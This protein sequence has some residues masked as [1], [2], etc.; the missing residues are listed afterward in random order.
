MAKKRAKRAATA[1]PAKKKAT[2]KKA[3]ARKKAPARRHSM[4]PDFAAVFMRLRGILRQFE[5]KM[6]VKQD[7]P[8][9][10]YMNT[11]IQTPRGPLFFGA[12]MT[13]KSYVSYHLFPVYMFP[14]L[15]QGISSSLKKRMQGKS[16]FNFATV[17][18][19][20]FD[21][22]AALT[23]RGAAELERGRRPIGV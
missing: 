3:T 15:L 17:D 8:G 2:K 13:K 22:L 21:E 7:K 16:C 6:S 19:G 11:R 9:N 14:D 18:E 5:D 4:P 20:L 10:Y 12:V 23:R 1:R